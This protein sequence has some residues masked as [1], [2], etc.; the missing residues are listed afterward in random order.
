MI[1]SGIKTR[2]RVRG[3]ERGFAGPLAG[4]GSDDTGMTF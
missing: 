1:G 4:C 3:G 2:R